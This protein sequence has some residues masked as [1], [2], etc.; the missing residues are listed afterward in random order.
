MELKKISVG[1]LYIVFISESAKRMY[2]G[3]S[4]GLYS[5]IENQFDLI[6]IIYTV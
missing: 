3:E 1:N 5:M 4:K 6:P 2:T